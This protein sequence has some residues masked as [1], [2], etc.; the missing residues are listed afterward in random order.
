MKAKV[1]VRLI[2]LTM[3]MLAIGFPL[4]FLTAPPI[5]RY[6]GPEG[7]AAS[8][9]ENLTSANFEEARKLVT[10]ESIET[11]HLFETLVGSQSDELKNEPTH[12]TMSRSKMNPTQDSLFI[13][14]KLFFSNKH[15]L[16]RHIELLLVNREGRWLVDCQDNNIF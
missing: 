10:P 5:P 4:L 16:I 8:F 9:V 7:I 15:K 12:F 1:R 14:G 6:L 2:L 3:T 11:M 13:E